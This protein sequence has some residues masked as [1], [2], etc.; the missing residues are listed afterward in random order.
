MSVLYRYV[1]LS[2]TKL[3]VTSVF[4]VVNFWIA[5]PSYVTNMY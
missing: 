5:L 4:A 2:T 3:P 1:D